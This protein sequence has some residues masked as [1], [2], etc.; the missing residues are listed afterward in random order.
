MNIFITG[1][2]GYIGSSVAEAFRRAGHEVWGLVRKAEQ[3]P[4]LARNEVQTVV[5]DLW[6]PDSYRRTAVEADALIHCAA[7]FERDREE[8][9]RLTIETMMALSATA[10][11]PKIVVFTSGTWVYG[12]ARGKVLTEKDPPA[13]KII[14]GGHRPAIEDRL[15]SNSSVRGLVIRPSNVYGR[16]GGQTGAWFEAGLSGKPPALIGAGDNI[17]P[18]VHV[19]DLAEGYLLAV[20]SGR[21]GIFNFADGSNLTY[22]EAMTAALRAAGYDGPI[23]STPLADALKTVGPM[24]EAYAQSTRIDSRKAARLLRW[25]PRHIGFTDETETYFEA[26]KAWRS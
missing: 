9:D 11:R 1:A 19:D 13:S 21:T 2:A 15:L 24:A 3:A 25:K 7:D 26:W 20:E 5:G 14:A 6:K 12:D 17:W 8:A 16:R 10:A 23:P 4:P 18:L 22:L